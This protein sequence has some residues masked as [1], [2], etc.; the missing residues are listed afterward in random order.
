MLEVQGEMARNIRAVIRSAN[1]RWSF[2]VRT[3]KDISNET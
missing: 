3:V 1:I 2:A